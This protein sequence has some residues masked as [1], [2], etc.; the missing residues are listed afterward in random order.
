MNAIKL[1]FKTRNLHIKY[2]NYLFSN[3][4][5]CKSHVSDYQFD[6]KKVASRL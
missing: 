6:K 5:T 1:R 3:H 2:K 4:V